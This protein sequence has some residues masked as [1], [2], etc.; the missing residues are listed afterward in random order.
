MPPAPDRDVDVPSAGI[1]A[2][3]FAPNTPTDGRG[4]GNWKSRY[5]EK[6]AQR[7]IVLEATIVWVFLLTALMLIVGVALQT[8]AN[9]V[10]LPEQATTRLTP[11]LLSFLGG[12]LG[13]TLFSMKWLYHTVAKGIWNRDRRL[14]RVF[15]PLLSAGAALTIILLCASGVLPF[16]GPDLVRGHAGALGLSIVFGYFSDRAISALG[17]VMTGIGMSAPGDKPTESARNTDSNSRPQTEAVATT[18][19]T[20]ALATA[21]ADSDPAR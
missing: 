16:F 11:Y 3:S 9:F 15:T 20:T 14:W 5:E 8:Q 17:N 2:P 6:S 7:A 18:H 12:F 21:E 4:E 13:G 19:D 1:S 10:P